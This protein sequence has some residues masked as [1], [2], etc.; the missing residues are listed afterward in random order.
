[1]MDKTTP[2]RTILTATK[3]T[4]PALENVPISGLKGVGEKL[5]KRLEKL[6]LY[7]VQDVLFHLPHR[8][9][10]RTRI[11]DISELHALQPA[12]IQGVITSSRV[13]F[14]KKRSLVVSLSD[15]TGQIVLRFYFFTAGQQKQLSEGQHIRCYGE[16]RPGALGLE[17]YHPEYQGVTS[18]DDIDGLEDTLTPIYSLTDGLSQK[19]LR[20]IT[21][22]ALTL[23]A[24]NPPNEYLPKDMT[25]RFGGYTLSQALHLAHNPPSSESI[26]ALMAGTHLCLQRLAFEE[27][28]AHNV[29]VQN[30]RLSVQKET[31]PAI[32]TPIQLKEK[33]LNTLPFSLTSAQ[34]R[35]LQEIEKDLTQTSPMHRLV[36][37]DVGSGKTLVAAL[38]ALSLLGNKFQVALV[39][40]TEILAEQHLTNFSQWLEPLG[41]N[42]AWL[43]GKVTAAKKREALA[44]LISGDAHI[45][46]GTHALFEESVIFQNLG[47]VIIDEQHRFGVQQRL[48]LRKK[49]NLYSPH[50]LMMTATPIPR[51]LAMTAYADMTLSII[52]ELPP[53]RTPVNTVMINQNKRAD[54]IERVRIACAEGQQAYWV[55]TLVEDSET[56]AASA[57]EDTCKLL[58]TA[59]PELN[60]GLVHGRLKSTEKETVMAAFK[61]AD[62]HL[63][64]ATTV[65]EV[66]VDVPNASLMIIENPERLG[67]AQLH[68]IRGRVG[69]GQRA[70]HCVLLYGHPL[71]RQGRQ[72]LEVLRNSNDGFVIAEKDLELR[73]PGELLGTQQTGDLHFRLANLQRDAALID[74]I[75]KVAK[76]LLQ[77]HPNIVNALIERWFKHHQEFAKA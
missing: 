7:S 44:Q 30:S 71:S 43:A 70:S 9:A 34:Q 67:L 49:G 12:V 31:A 26:N 74:D 47:L 14:G 58:Q 37:G 63:L 32:N 10:D 64:V 69:R 19:R 68:Q 22:Q 41:F 2:G 77:H 18:L 35:V 21:L 33:L 23:L 60:I 52:D 61:K 54:I 51:T 38:S 11:A 50:Q 46:V 20:K 48:S 24:S 75:H 36:Q 28:L 72:R 42:V 65:I 66:G 8:Y 56:L 25:E 39:A 16:P 55:C 13:V 6:H 3:S 53:G 73:G 40:P 27:L 4:P 76:S 15:N 57:A 62:L 17:M 5:A 29:A 45:A 1:M 59:A